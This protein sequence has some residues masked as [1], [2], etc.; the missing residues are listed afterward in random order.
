MATL[1]DHPKSFKGGS[2]LPVRELARYPEPSLVNRQAQLMTLFP[3]RLSAIKA[4]AALTHLDVS[5]EVRMNLTVENFGLSKEF[6]QCLHQAKDKAPLLTEIEASKFCVLEEIS[7]QL[8]MSM[9]TKQLWSHLL[10][11]FK[12]YCSYLLSCTKL[13]TLKLW[14]EAK[15]VLSTLE[16]MRKSLCHSQTETFKVLS[17]LWLQIR[18]QVG[19]LCDSVKHIDQDLLPFFQAFNL[20]MRRYVKVSF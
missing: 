13:D 11:C 5:P 3:N 20:S 6:V 16:S 17:V 18:L 12:A 4:F 15:P 9:D 10:A 14:S 8:Q 19:Q 2:H 7:N 1:A